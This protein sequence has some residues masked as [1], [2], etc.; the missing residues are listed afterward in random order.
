MEAGA[1]VRRPGRAGR[2]R[3]IALALSVGLHLLIPFAMLSTEPPTESTVAPDPVVVG[4]VKSPPPPPS[5]PARTAE[6]PA[7]PPEPAPSQAPPPPPTPP[8]P[9]V[10]PVPVRQVEA[11]PAPLPTLS[12]AQLVGARTAG[13][14]GAGGGGGAGSGAGGAPC[15]MVRRLQAALRRDADVQA[16]AARAHR[17]TGTGR[18]ILVWNGD[19]V[20]SPD[21]EG[22]GLAG[23]RQA[24]TMEV[25]FAPEACRA[26]PMS[27]LVVIS[28][29]DGPGAA[30]LVLGRAAWRWPELLSARRGAVAR[31]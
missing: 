7:G 14:G 11:P 30:R 19:W 3:W 29:N 28:M 10:E 6:L 26:E 8:P 23:V 9:E 16:A 13:H 18:A 15:D 4:L 25:A 24:I 5:P 2:G 27:G 12:D 1:G 22:K 31:R 21:Q 17:S 20:R